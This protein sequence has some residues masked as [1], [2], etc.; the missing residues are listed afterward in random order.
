[1]LESMKI[2]VRIAEI[3]TLEFAEHLV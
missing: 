1:M 3:A 2:N